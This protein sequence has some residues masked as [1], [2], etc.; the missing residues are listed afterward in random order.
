LNESRLLDADRQIFEP[1]EALTRDQHDFFLRVLAL[2]GIN[3]FN[4]NGAAIHLPAL[5]GAE[6]SKHVTDTRQ[7]FHLGFEL[8]TYSDEPSSDEPGGSFIVISNS[9]WS[10]CGM[11]LLPTIMNSGMVD[12]NT[13][14]R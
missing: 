12:R 13:S 8:R 11:K 9:L 14:D 6:D 7:R 10:S 2:F 5:V 4:Q 1:A 3:Q